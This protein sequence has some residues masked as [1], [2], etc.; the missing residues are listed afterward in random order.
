M[1][2]T[3]VLTA[4][5][6]LAAPASAAAPW[7]DPQRVSSPHLSV[8]ARALVAGQDGRILALW[9]SEDFG[10]SIRTEGTWTASRTSG[11]TGF[12][13]QRRVKA[14]LYDARAYGKNRVVALTRDERRVAVAFGRTDGR[15]GSPQTIAVARRRIAATALA[16]N[17][18][19]AIAVAWIVDRGT[20][21]DDLMVSVRPPKGDFSKPLRLVREKLRG[22]S[23]AIGPRGEVLVAWNAFDRVRARI[24]P[25]G[26]RMFGRTDTIRS[27][28][29]FNARLHTDVNAAGRAVVAWSAR[30]LSEGG[31]AGPGFVQSAVRLSGTS[32]FRPA[33]RL[34]TGDTGTLELARGPGREFVVAW[35]GAGGAIRAATTRGSAF[36]TPAT[37]DTGGEIGDLAVN[38][39]GEAVVVWHRGDAIRAA[40]YRVGAFGTPQLVGP[41]RDT[42]GPVHAIVDPHTDDVVV[43]WT[44]RPDGRAETRLVGSSRG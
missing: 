7:S 1:R 27:E 10:A 2:R 11:A 13:P 31:T 14:D 35:R 24:R 26:R 3:L 40:D 12:G 23:A 5:L 39:L 34:E 18:R 20:N 16:T 38:P 15:F 29:A 25:A 33:A 30:F 19:G 17:E 22:V 44:D 6:L 21:N 32:R 42:A 9:G 8:T 36:G 41:A 37:V 4:T 28:D 43:I